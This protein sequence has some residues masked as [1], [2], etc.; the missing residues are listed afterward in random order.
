M[1]VLSMRILSA[2]RIPNSDRLWVYTADAGF[3]P[4]QFVA[5]LTHVYEVGDLVAVAQVGTILPSEIPGG[6]PLV[7]CKTRIRG[8]ET[9]GMGLGKTQAPV[10]TDLSSEYHTQ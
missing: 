8:V 2:D 7:I 1:P 9:L 3:G 5:N 6:E 10:G 4:L